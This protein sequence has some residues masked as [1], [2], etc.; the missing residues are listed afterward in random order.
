M[1]ATR[2]LFGRRLDV[3]AGRF[4]PPGCS[5]PGSHCRRWLVLGDGSADPPTPDLPST[6]AACGRPLFVRFVVLIGVA[7]DRL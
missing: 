3:V 5:G 6:C 7:A 2:T 4:R 1:R